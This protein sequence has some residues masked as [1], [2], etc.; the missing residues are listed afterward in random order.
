MRCA[1]VEFQNKFFY[2]DGI[3]FQPSTIEK[4]KMEGTI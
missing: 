4:E 2:A 3:A 1:L